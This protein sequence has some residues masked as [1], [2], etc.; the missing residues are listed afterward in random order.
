[1]KVLDESMENQVNRGKLLL[2]KW[3]AVAP[4]NQEKHFLVTGVTKDENGVVLTCTVEAV[5]TKNAIEMDWQTFKDC[6]LW[7]VGWH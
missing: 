7:L 6:T 1:M 2:S 4:Q 5:L 3:T